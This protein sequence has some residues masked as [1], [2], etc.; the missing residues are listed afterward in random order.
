MFST[1]SGYAVVEEFLSQRIAHHQ[2]PA[3]AGERGH[4]APLEIH[5][6]GQA[7]HLAADQRLIVLVDGLALG[8]IQAGRQQPVSVEP[9]FPDPRRSRPAVELHAGG[10]EQIVDRHRLED[11]VPGIGGR[12]PSGPRRS[13][14][15]ACP[16]RCTFSRR[17][18]SRATDSRRG[19]L[20]PVE[21]VQ[22]VGVIGRH[23]IGDGKRSRLRSPRA[24]PPGCRGRP[25]S[26]RRRRRSARR[27]Y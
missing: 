2:A 1:P 7:A 8:G 14:R 23:G 25:R 22:V 18:R 27:P 15:R 21:V 6:L 4:Q 9:A 20:D 19:R 24:A 16:W 12:G 13:P 5:M 3:R 10:G 11:D 17:Q 26:E